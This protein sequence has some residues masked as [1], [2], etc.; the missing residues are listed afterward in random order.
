M[1]FSGNVLNGITSVK[2]VMFL[3]GFVC[4]FVSLFVSLYICEQ[5][6]SKIYGP[7]L[8]QFSGYV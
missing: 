5:D 1:K 4:G 8:M 6:N 2:E 7:I 3:P